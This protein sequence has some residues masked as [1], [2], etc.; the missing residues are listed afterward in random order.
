MIPYILAIVGGYLIGNSAKQ[1]VRGGYLTNKKNIEN[2]KLKSIDGGLFIDT[3]SM[4]SANMA[5]YGIWKRQNW[6]DVFYEITFED[7]EKIEGSID[8][9]PHSFHKGH[10]NNILTWHINTF[11]NNIANTN[12]PYISKDDKIFAK[13]IVENYKLYADGGMNNKNYI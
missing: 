9:E 8:L 12:A 6:S 5:L 10:E 1:Y 13:K 4:S 2:I 11:W 3:N 7:G